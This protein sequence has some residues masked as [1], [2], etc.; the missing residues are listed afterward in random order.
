MKIVRILFP[1]LVAFFAVTVNAQTKEIEVNGTVSDDDG[2]RITGTVIENIR[3]EA[4]VMADDFGDYSILATMGDSLSFEFLGYVPQARVVNGTRLNVRMPEDTVGIHTIVVTGSEH[5]VGNASVQRAKEI[6][7]PRYRA[8]NGF[9]FDETATHHPERIFI[10]WAGVQSEESREPGMQLDIRL[11]HEVDRSGVA[12]VFFRDRTSGEVRML[13]RVEENPRYNERVFYNG[14]FRIDTMRY[15]RRA[16]RFEPGQYDVIVLYNDGKYLTKEGVVFTESMDQILDMTPVRTTTADA[17][18]REWLKMRKFTDII[19]ARKLIKNEAMKASSHKIIGYL[20]GPSEAALGDWGTVS[21]PP[22]REGEQR[23]EASS[24]YDGFFELDVD[25]ESKVYPMRLL[26]LYTPVEM[27]AK[28]NTWIFA[29][30]DKYDFPVDPKLEKR[31]AR[32]H[33]RS[34]RR[35][36]R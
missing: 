27:E 17:A 23:R 1:I 36:R 9:E 2:Y 15:F 32:D 28:A 10:K 18:S 26:S 24:F 7:N 5:G 25:S 35:A 33:A 16:N 21:L 6:T 13:D 31:I 20:F 22:E 8:W 14:E 12:N 19:G 3:T 34:A 30:S 29:V 4:R 11:P